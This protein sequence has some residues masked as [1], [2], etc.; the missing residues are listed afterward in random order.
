MMKGDAMRSVEGTTSVCVVRAADGEVEVFTSLDDARQYA[1]SKRGATVLE[2]PVRQA[3]SEATVVYERR[4]H[5]DH[6]NVR[7]DTTGEE[8]FFT[9]CDDPEIP[10]AD[11]ESF[12]TKE[13]QWTV[14]G[15]GTDRSLVDKLV[16]QEITRLRAAAT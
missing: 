2:R 10:S 13:Q 3:L 1:R 16:D 8:P 9:L 11:V 15:L 12:E 5:I 7:I 14:L 4:L 6:G